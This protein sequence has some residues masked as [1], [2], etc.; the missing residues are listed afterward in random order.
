MVSLVE[1]LLILPAHLSGKGFSSKLKI[2]KLIDRIQLWTEKRLEAF[3]NGQFADF[4][5]RTV[6]WR[7]VTLA[8]GCAIFIITI[9]YITG[10]Y[11]KVVF[12]DPV[13][14]DN[15]VSFLTMPKG[16]PVKQT[17]EIADSIEK[18]VVQVQQEF[19][20]NRPGKASIIKHVAT[21]IGDQPAARGGGP[22]RGIAIGSAAH[23]AEVNVE[24]LGGEERDVSST[25]LKNRWR[26][27]VGEIPG[28]SSLTFFSEF[29][30]A[31]EAINIEMSHQNFDTLLLAVETLKSI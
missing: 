5:I 18:A 3:V 8:T 22:V 30:S 27:I 11:I 29:F 23:L 2:F 31:G 13:E 10:G 12:F 7:Y 25:I 28:V 16:T 9:G 4:V 17:Q 14:A 15:M 6:K 1:A 20:T 26:E 24:L 19:D 21:T